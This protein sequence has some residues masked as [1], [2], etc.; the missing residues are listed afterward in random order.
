VGVITCIIPITLIAG[1]GAMTV[2]AGVMTT[3]IPIT[4]IAGAGALTGTERIDDVSST[5][6]FSCRRGANGAANTL[7]IIPVIV[8]WIDA[9]RGKMFKDK[10]QLALW[11]E[12]AVA[13]ILTL[14]HHSPY[15]YRC[16]SCIDWIKARCNK[17][18]TRGALVNLTHIL[19]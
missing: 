6:S 12:Q 15:W 1:A 10:R 13:N 17:V 3:I 19:V 2:V 4:F 7:P 11:L 16:G 14:H 9:Q 5:R 18:Q 8:D